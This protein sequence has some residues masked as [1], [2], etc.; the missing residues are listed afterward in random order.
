ML[1]VASERVILSSCCGSFVY[2]SG[3]GFEYS[4]EC[5]VQCCQN[6]QFHKKKEKPSQATVSTA[7]GLKRK[8]DLPS[9]IADG[10]SSSGGVKEKKN[11]G[12]YAKNPRSHTT[13]AAVGNGKIGKLNPNWKIC[14]ICKQ[15]NIQQSLPLLD[16]HHR[17]IIQHPLCAKH[18][19]PHHVCK[20]LWDL[21]GIYRFFN[22]RN[23]LS[24]SSCDNGGN[25]GGVNVKTKFKKKK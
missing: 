3:S 5:G 16:I 19:I 22:Q 4:T 10:S 21:D 17:A 25:S 14:I 20:S 1:V 24:L 23:S 2:Y 6:L 15:K 9:T 12:V 13:L 11:I 18:V 7:K 8:L